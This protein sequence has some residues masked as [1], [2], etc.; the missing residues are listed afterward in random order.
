M[1]HD[2]QF[3]DSRP[4]NPPQGDFKGNQIFKSPP[5]GDLGG[6]DGALQLP[7]EIIVATGNKGKLEE[8]K[9][10]MSD[11][12]IVLTSLRDYWDPVVA[13]PEDGETFQENAFAKARWVFS[14]T[15]KP[16]LADDSGLEVDF[17][18][19]QPGIRSA[20]FA[21]EGA[22]DIKNLEKLLRLLKE[23]P[24]EKRQARFRCAL[25]LIVSEKEIITAEGSCEGVIIDDPAGDNGFGYDPVFVPSGFDRTFAQLDS[26]VKNKISHRG[27]ALGE[28]K[29]K[30]HE[31]VSSK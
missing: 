26:I 6:V 17:L 14:R 16:C 10:L 29:K 25:A 9:T 11:L 27:K 8:I 18:N 24:R 5:A 19:G 23:C 4:L 28:L 30:L 20:R 7:H 13:I 2:G 31:F 21:G 1:I 22:T 12:P 3:Q 15:G